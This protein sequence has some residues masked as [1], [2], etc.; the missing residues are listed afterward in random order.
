M[1]DL[2]LPLA[3]ALGHE[4]KTV[5]LLGEEE[6]SATE[7]AEILESQNPG[8]HVVGLACPQIHIRGEQLAEAMQ[9]DALVLEEINKT[10]PDIL[11]ISLEHPKQ[12][13]WFE[14]VRHKLRIPLVVGITES[15]DILKGKTK[16]KFKPFKFLGS[17]GRYIWNGMTLLYL[18][19]PLIV[20]HRIN[21][22]IAWL[23]SSPDDEKVA[24]SLLFL[25]P[26][27]SIAVIRLP[28]SLNSSNC[29]EI[30]QNMEEAF[31]QD[32][33]MLDAQKT[34]HIDIEGIGLLVRAWQRAKE[35]N[36]E[37]YGFGVKKRIS[38]LLSLHKVWDMF[39]T[40]ICSSSA[41]LTN[42]LLHHTKSSTLYDSV[43]Q[44]EETVVL[45]FFGKLDNA[46]N[47][48]EYIGKF[49]GMLE[50][51]CL[52]DFTYCSFIDNAGFSFLLHLKQIVE[53][54]GKELQITNV[55]KQLYKLFKLAKLNK[56][57]KKF[58]EKDFL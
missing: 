6:E 17:L 57:F 4:K 49:S 26:N 22:F 15:F 24:K 29:K 13:I 42:R 37:F 46:Q 3:K 52:I 23:G 7:A 45:S 18:L 31:A 40:E 21:Q 2:I 9:R 28:V 25:S 1:L 11:L 58:Q 34:K 30:S 8:L 19:I 33:L 14:R 20:Y 16:R 41:D 12:E 47:Y 54:N 51:D 44:N 35:A 53:G 48:E 56:V 5:F 27:R 43:Y 32:V 55:S 50:K 39:S 10:S 38:T 36:K